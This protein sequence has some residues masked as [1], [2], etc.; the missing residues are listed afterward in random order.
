MTGL[1]EDGTAVV[2]G[3]SGA[4]GGAA[5]RAFA[6]EGASVLVAGTTRAK[7]DAVVADVVAAGGVARGAVVDA[8]DPHAVD[9]VV[10]AAVAAF[11]RLDVCYTAVGIDNGEQGVALADLEPEAYLRPIREYAAVHFHT[12][13]S[14]ARVMR[15][16]GCGVILALS[17][18]MTRAAPAMTGA[19]AP[20]HAVIETMVRQMAA[21]LGPDGIRAAALRPTGMPDSVRRAGS[22]V[23]DIWDRM[24][25]R[26]GGTLDEV[27]P[28]VG[29]GG[30]LGTEMTTVELAEVTA[31]LASDRAR[32]LT[33]TVLNA[34]GGA[35]LD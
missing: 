4:V 5:V 29:A 18:P 6:R 25:R 1:L 35:V 11:G 30:L 16:R 20:A 10:D 24:A 31:F 34:S 21:E 32:V 33:G 2:F 8:R 22:H 26:S 15:P 28:A 23:G 27:L 13:R 7:V 12:A 9:A 19:F 17:A 14:A 3:G